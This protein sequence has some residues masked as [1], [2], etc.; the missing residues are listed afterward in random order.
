ML[1]VKNSRWLLSKPEH[2]AVVH[3]VN[4][5]MDVNKTPQKPL[6][7]TQYKAL[8]DTF[9]K[10][11]CDLKFVPPILGL[12]EM[13]FTANA[14]LV[15]GRRCVLARFKFS[16]RQGEER[17]FQDWFEQNGFEVIKL[18]KGFHEGEGDALFV[19]PGVLFGGYG[20]GSDRA[21][22]DEAADLLG[23]K[24]LVNCEL[25]D[26]RF[27]HLD[28]C[29]TPIDA[30]RAL[31]VEG[32]FSRESVRQME[33]SIELFPVT[34]NDALGFACNA[35]VLEHNVILPTNCTTTEKLLQSWGFKTHAVAM[36]EYL[37][38]SGAT[39]C[40]SLRLDR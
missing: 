9:V 37:K 23:C 7:E 10:L 13:V 11:G 31:F 6:A 29:F 15:V 26:G 3:H 17:Y 32:A 16:Q 27:Y 4:Q 40:L 8:V 22:Q 24:S 30:N 33:Q 5:S 20:F 18:T 38:S 34:E 12:P 36:S 39:K 35:V 1:N 21:A 19:R 25:V 2:Y 14:G 28:T